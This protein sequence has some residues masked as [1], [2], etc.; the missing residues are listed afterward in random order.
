MIL[1]EVVNFPIFEMIRGSLGICFLSALLSLGLFANVL[2]LFGH[3]SAI[4]GRVRFIFMFIDV[5]TLFDSPPLSR[6]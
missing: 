5:L 2:R 6:D 1:S 4:P 3:T